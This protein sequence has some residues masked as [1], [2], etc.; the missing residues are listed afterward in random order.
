MTSVMISSLSGI[1]VCMCT[2]TL[3]PDGDISDISVIFSLSKS[4]WKMAHSMSFLS[5]SFIHNTPLGV[6][7][8]PQTRQSIYSIA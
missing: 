6:S 2:F 7:Q 8:L 5:S 3:A 1:P 4:S